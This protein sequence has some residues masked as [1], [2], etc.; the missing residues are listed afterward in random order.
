VTAR[1][2]EAATER[3]RTAA[4]SRSDGTA[5]RRR[6]LTLAAAALAGAAA[7]VLL[8]RPAPGDAI[9]ETVELALSASTS[10]PR[11]FA[12]AE[13]PGDLALVAPPA[14]DALQAPAAP[15]SF[16]VSDDLPQAR[17]APAEG[18]EAAHYQ[19]FLELGRRDAAR[20]SA[21]A[22]RVFGTTTSVPDN[23]RVAL[24]RALWETGAPDAGRWF[25]AAILAPSERALPEAPVPDFA[26]RFLAKRAPREPAAAAA[27]ADAVAA[28]PPECDAAR[29]ARAAAALEEIPTDVS[30][31]DR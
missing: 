15:P 10:A 18:S 12:A 28:A 13:L 27:L 5:A 11:T 31:P 24:L 7:F 20:L 23:E 25:R 1:D 14:P 26:V 17:R 16:A 21:E 22:E 19:R 9:D 4:T 6:G 3:R 2:E 29:L 30:E 8:L